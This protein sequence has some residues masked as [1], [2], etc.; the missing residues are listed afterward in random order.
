MTPSQ[1]QMHIYAFQQ[2]QLHAVAA[3]Y[4]QTQQAQGIMANG[5]PG[6]ISAAVRSPMVQNSQLTGNV[7]RS[8]PLNGNTPQ[9]SRSPM[10]PGQQPGV[11][12]GQH[13]QQA[14]TIQ[15]MQTQQMYNFANYNMAR[16]TGMPQNPSTL[17]A[18]HAMQ[19]QQ[20]QAQQRAQ[21]QAQTQTQT[22]Q[23]PQS[24]QMQ[25]ATPEQQQQ[26]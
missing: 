17:A 3:R 26:A 7:A 9:T 16:M 4:G 21:Q 2:Q 5:T 6:S 11:G 18:M 22:Q 12:A 25:A 10:P 23:S 20:A 13:S 14:T 24:P 1:H 15:Q 19:A 8:S